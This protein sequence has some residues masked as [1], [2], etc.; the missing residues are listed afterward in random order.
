MSP[1]TEVKVNEKGKKREIRNIIIGEEKTLSLF[2]DNVIYPKNS[3]E[4]IKNYLSYLG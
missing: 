1:Y 3:S 2:I 4:Y